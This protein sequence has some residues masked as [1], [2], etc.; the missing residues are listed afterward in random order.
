[1]KK[2]LWCCLLLRPPIV[3]ISMAIAIFPSY[4]S[5]VFAGGTAFDA[6][7]ISSMGSANA[8]MAAEATDASVMFANPAALTRL[9]R[10]EVVLG[11]AFVGINSSYTSGQTPDGSS[12]NSGT[13]GSQ[14]QEFNRKSGYDATALA[15]NL[16]VA[17]PVNKKLVVGFGAA[18]SHALI[19]RYDENFPGRNQGRDIDFKVSRANLGFGY[20]LTPSL[21][22]GANGSYERYFQ[23][24]KLK[25]N[26]RDAVD[27]LLNNGSTLLDGLNQAGLAPPIPDEADLSLRMFGWAFNA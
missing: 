1:M 7:S 25:L 11:A 14:G 21:S 12:T 3:G 20:K 22:I 24:L 8:G 16:F 10:A 6:T 18:A 27:G 23:S 5:K 13:T 19:V 17:I 2:R 15:P 26:Y 9:K 4:S